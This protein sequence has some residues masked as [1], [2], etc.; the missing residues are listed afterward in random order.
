MFKKLLILFL[1]TCFC[2]SSFACFD[3]PPKICTCS[4]YGD[5]LAGGPWFLGISSAMRAQAAKYQSLY[6]YAVPNKIQPL[7]INNNKFYYFS[8]NTTTL[9]NMRD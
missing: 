6:Y 9:N 7:T 8:L 4:F 2:F 3:E 5:P 1:L